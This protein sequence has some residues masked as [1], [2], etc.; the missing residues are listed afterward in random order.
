[1]NV[2]STLSGT[3]ATVASIDVANNR[4]TLSA[5]ATNQVHCWWHINYLW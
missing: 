2:T 3:G 1:M 4:V 5:V